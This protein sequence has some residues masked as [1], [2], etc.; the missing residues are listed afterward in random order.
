MAVPVIIS[1]ELVLNPVPLPAPEPDPENSPTFNNFLSDLRKARWRQSLLGTRGG[2]SQSDNKTVRK[3][4]NYLRCI[5]YRSKE[6]KMKGPLLV[7][8]AEEN[9]APASNTVAHFDA[10]LLYLIHGYEQVSARS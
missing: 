8:D 4:P 1:K 10:N 7:H 6:A 2:F 5:Q 3:L 9:G